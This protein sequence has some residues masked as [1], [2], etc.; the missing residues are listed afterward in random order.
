MK[1]THCCF[2]LLQKK[3]GKI[4]AATMGTLVP[5]LC[6][7]STKSQNTS[8]GQGPPCT[9]FV[10]VQCWNH[11]GGLPQHRTLHTPFAVTYPSV[12]PGGSPTQAYI[13]TWVLLYVGSANHGPLVCSHCRGV[14]PPPSRASLQAFDEHTAFV[15]QGKGTCDLVPV[16]RRSLQWP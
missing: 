8:I 4:L 5:K 6:P 12:A 2:K 14:L 9:L 10:L 15:H 1:K 3:T 16:A 13:F 11:N 7:G